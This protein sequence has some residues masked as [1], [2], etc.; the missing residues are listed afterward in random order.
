MLKRLL[1][2]EVTILTT[3]HVYGEP[4]YVFTCKVDALKRK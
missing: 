2:V 3:V 4:F 1:S